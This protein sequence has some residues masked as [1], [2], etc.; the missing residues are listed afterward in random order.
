MKTILIATD[1]SHASRNASFFGIGLAKALGANILLFNSFKSSDSQSRPGDAGSLY[2][3]M[4]KAEA[5][6]LDEA[7]FLDPGHKLMEVVC[8]DG[9]AYRTILNVAKEKNVDFIVVGRKGN[10][11]SIAELFGSTATALGKNTSVPL[12]IVP[13]NAKFDTAVVKMSKEF[14][15]GM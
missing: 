7:D 5:Q 11:D 1:F 4:L 8:E 13:E 10:G 14:T 6:L 2:E 12:I 3:I 9:E 15:A